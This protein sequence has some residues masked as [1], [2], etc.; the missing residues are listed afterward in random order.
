MIFG[1]QV[2]IADLTDR[3]PLPVGV[4]ALA[5]APLWALQRYSPSSMGWVTEAPTIAEGVRGSFPLRGDA[6]LD[7]LKQFG[8]RMSAVDEKDI[9]PGRDRLADLGFSVEPTSALDW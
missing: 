1:F 8:S 3:L 7:M 4:Q 5:C 2:C 9:L 6:S